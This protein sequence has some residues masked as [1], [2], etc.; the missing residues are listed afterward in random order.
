MLISVLCL[1]SALSVRFSVCLHSGLPTARVPTTSHLWGL[2]A[3]GQGAPKQVRPELQDPAAGRSAGR[4]V[5]EEIKDGETTLKYLNHLGGGNTLLVSS[6]VRGKDGYQ[7]YIC[8]RVQSIG[9]HLSWT[10]LLFSILNIF[11][12]FHSLTNAWISALKWPNN[13]QVRI[14]FSS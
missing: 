6:R 2:W 7:F 1:L 5:E 10:C 12:I 11:V 14:C 13:K 9:F 3:S 8:V 4:L